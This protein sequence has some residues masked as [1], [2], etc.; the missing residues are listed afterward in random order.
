MWA[1]FMGYNMAHEPKLVILM[2]NGIWIHLHIIER[3]FVKELKNH[4]MMY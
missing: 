1:K 2:E 4:K 3:K